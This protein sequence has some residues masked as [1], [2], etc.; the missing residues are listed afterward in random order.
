MIAAPHKSSAAAPKRCAAEEVPFELCQFGS[1]VFDEVSTLRG[2]SGRVIIVTCHCC[3]CYYCL[4]CFA[5]DFLGIWILERQLRPLRA[6]HLSRG[7]LRNRRHVQFIFVKKTN[8]AGFLFCVRPDH[9]QSR[10]VCD[11]SSMRQSGAGGRKGPETRRPTPTNE[12]QKIKVKW[13]QN[14]EKG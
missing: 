7:M 2:K 6:L 8:L 4:H 11:L 1:F 14:L 12:K 10:S 5:V 9:H 13:N 3:D